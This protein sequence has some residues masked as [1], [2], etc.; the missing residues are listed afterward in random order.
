MRPTIIDRDSAPKGVIFRRTMRGPEHD[1]LDGFISAMPLVHAPDSRV[2]VLREPGLES[3]YPDLVIVVW[4]DGR[5]SDWDE[6]RM[7]LVQEDLRLMHYVFQRR[8]VDQS[9]IENYF[10]LRFARRSVARLHG[11]G[12]VRPAGTAW[13]PCAFERTFAATKII[14]IEAK[15]GKWTEV[16]NQA[17][18]NTWF[19]SKSYVLVPRASEDQVRE[20]SASRHWSARPRAKWSRGMGRFHR[21]LAALVCLLGRQ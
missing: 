4:R 12:L 1:L 10:G 11:A 21:A 8:R 19:A 2:T 14:A 15:I 9:E 7:A 17:R 3:G 16:L 20:G 18:L 5:T 13:F 6:S